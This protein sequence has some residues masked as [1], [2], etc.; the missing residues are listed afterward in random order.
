MP[1]ISHSISIAAPRDVIF[2]LVSSGHGFQRWWAADVSEDEDTE[3][4][5]LA[6]FNRNTIYRLK[7]VKNSTPWSAE[8]FCESGEEWAGTTLLFAMTE[9][10][11]KTQ[12]NF[13]HSGWKAETPYFVSCTKTWGDL[14]QRIKAAAEG[15]NP[16]PFFT[17]DGTAT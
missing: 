9:A 14:L 6:F 16:G 4:V 5:E 1:E 10:G 12:L 3:I 7:P 11:G 15:Q 13:T 17:K 8:W 2:P